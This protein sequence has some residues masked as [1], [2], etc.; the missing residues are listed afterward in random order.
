[1]FAGALVTTEKSYSFYIVGV[2]I[3]IPLPPKYLKEKLTYVRKA[4]I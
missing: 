3:V 1:L 4:L 2:L